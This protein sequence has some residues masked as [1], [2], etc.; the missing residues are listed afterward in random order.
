MAAAEVWLDPRS[1]SALRPL[2]NG[3][4]YVIRRQAARPGQ[5]ALRLRIEAGSLLE[6]DAQQG[7]A[8]FLEHMAFKGSKA[9]PDG[10]MV[11][12][13]ERHGLAF[14]ADTNASTDFDQTVYKL[15]LPRTDDDTVDT[16]LA[17]LREAA[18]E[19]TLDQAAMD[20]ERG[21]VLSEE[22]TRDTPYF[23]LFGSRLRFQLKDQRPGDRFPIGKVDV[24]RTAPVS[25][26]ADYYRK[27]YRPERTVLIAVGDFDPAVMEAKIRESVR[28][29]GR[30][31]PAGKEPGLG[32]V[33][34]RKLE[35]R[36]MVDP[37]LATSIG[38]A[39]VRPP[40]PQSLTPMATR[41][42]DLLKQLGFT[43]LNRRLQAIAR[44]PGS[45]FLSSGAFATTEY[46][47]ATITNL[48]VNA[49]FG[50]WKE[51]LTRAEL[52]QRRLLQ[53]GVRQ[54]E[55]D[56]EIVELRTALKASAAGAATILPL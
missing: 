47:A 46:K 31:G 53:F 43:V 13:L 27:Y 49:D 51:A 26:I 7:L 10:E 25:Q 22:R 21:V 1:G 56:R 45:P 18:G 9:Y 4:R 14:G 15:D 52:E 33:K 28:Q 2:P 12:I 55:L 24:L 6:S 11:R 19:L 42:E 20:S 40:D 54:D 16:T 32:K 37:G 17:L 48:V 38:V 41:R 3:M 5:A 44:S 36:L 30:P 35:A 39:W 23:R 8:H 29:L 50:Q 34:S